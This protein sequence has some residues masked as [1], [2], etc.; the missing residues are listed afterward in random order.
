LLTLWGWWRWRHCRQLAGQPTAR[1]RLQTTS[2]GTDGRVLCTGDPFCPEPSSG[3]KLG[4]KAGNWP[5]IMVT[6]NLLA[7]QAGWHFRGRTPMMELRSLHGVI[8]SMSSGS[9]LWRCFHVAPQGQRTG[10]AADGRKPHRQQRLKTI[11]ASSAPPTESTPNPCVVH[12]HL[13]PVA[14]LSARWCC[15]RML[16]LVYH[17]DHGSLLCVFV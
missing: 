17:Q 12:Q 7:T 15:A 4:K 9:G 3:Y 1:T 6:A 16:E 13:L 2:A 14:A 10:K 11:C 5:N 8:W